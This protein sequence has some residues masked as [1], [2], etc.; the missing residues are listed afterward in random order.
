MVSG[1]GKCSMYPNYRFNSK[2]EQDRH[3]TMFHPQGKSV[4]KEPTLE[5]AIC[6]KNFSIQSSLN[7]HKLKDGHDMC[8]VVN[9]DEPPQKHK[10]KTKQCMINEMLC[11]HQDWIR[12][13]ES[14]GDKACSATNC[15]I[16]L[17]RMQLSSGYVVKNVTYGSTTW[18][19]LISKVN[20]R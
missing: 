11:N 10:C 14:D 20:L 5:C 4:Y 13:N 15:Q 12:V 2:M 8:A 18:C 19:V 1:L 6:N 7:W 9:T 16:N 3:K 17:G